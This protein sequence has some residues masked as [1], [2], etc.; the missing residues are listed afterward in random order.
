MYLLLNEESPRHFLMRCKTT[1]SSEVK[2]FIGSPDTDDM[3][4]T[5]YPSAEPIERLR[6]NGYIV[7]PETGITVRMIKVR[8]PDG[9][10]E[11]LLRNL[12]DNSVFTR[13]KISRLYFMRWRIE[14]SY[15]KQKN[16]LQTEIFSGH[17][18]ICIEQDYAAGLFVANL[19]SIIEKQCE[20][21]I[22]KEKTKGRCYDYKINRNVSWAS[23]KYRIV[24]LLIYPDESL[25]ILIE[26]QYLFTRYLEPVRPGR[27]FPISLLKRKRGKYQTFTNYRR[28]INL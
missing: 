3:V 16:Q 27:H 7:T 15:D 5:P 21:Q 11:V 13:K 10:P 28:A 24:R 19:Q 6:N 8:L 20:E 2:K 22:I 9:E 25:A 4:T 1:F 18:V 17:R 12:C 23:L 14:T 26:L